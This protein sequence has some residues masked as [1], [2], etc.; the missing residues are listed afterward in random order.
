MSSN[1]SGIVTTA[2]PIPSPDPGARPRRSWSGR[3]AS[4]VRRRSTW[5]AGVA[6]AALVALLA[7]TPAQAGP[8]SS[9]ARPSVAAGPTIVLV[10]GA[11]SGPSSWNEV[12]SAL[13]KDGYTTVAVTLP[14][15]GTVDDIA[16]VRATLDAVPGPKVVVGHS[17]GGFVIT[18][19]TA[20]RSDVSAL[21]YTAA[22]VPAPGE[23]II[24]LG[25]GYAPAA[26]L[27]PGHLTF[28]STGR[29]TIT[30]T[31][32]RDDFAQDLNPRLAATL[33]HAQTPT[34]LSILFAP[35]AEVAWPAIPSWYA[36]SGADR[37]ID[38]ALQRSMAARAG[39]TTVTFDDA[40]HAGGFTHYSARFTKLVEQAAAGR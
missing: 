38:P 6:L 27:A 33:D 13:R 16:T 8:A 2:P 22:F 18:D 39:A 17:Y 14:L 28:D 12:A 29:A 20:G 3:G 5:L 11:F 30:S 26:F 24:G 9:V 7:G 19:A 31:S 21:V 37:V 36:V 23:S 25:A 35:S 1:R 34:D 15:S 4:G 40:S 10:H 32:F